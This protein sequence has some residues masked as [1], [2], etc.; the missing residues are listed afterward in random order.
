MCHSVCP[1]KPYYP[2]MFICK[3][4]LQWLIRLVWGLW[5]QL[6]Y[7]YQI[8]TRNPLRQPVVALCHRNPTALRLFHVLQELID[9]VDVGEVQFKAQDTSLGGSWVGQSASFLASTRPGWA[10]QHY[11]S[12]SLSALASK[13]QG[14]LSYSHAL[15]AGV[16][17][18]H[19][20]TS[21]SSVMPSQG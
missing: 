14:Q 19:T 18:T 4:L 2:Y 6:H 3:A 1:S 20:S 16:T 15:G 13:R 10:L 17:Y 5:L 12:E 7:Q 11:P 8:P 21:I 9:E